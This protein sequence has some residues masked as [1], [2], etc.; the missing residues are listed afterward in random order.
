MPAQIING[1]T[2]SMREQKQDVSMSTGLPYMRTHRGL[3]WE[4]SYIVPL[5][6]A[7]AGSIVSCVRS[8]RCRPIPDRCVSIN[9]WALLRLDIRS[10]P[11]VSRRWCILSARSEAKVLLK[12]WVNG[13]CPVLSQTKC[14]AHAPS[15]GSDCPS[16][17][18]VWP[19]CAEGFAGAYSNGVRSLIHYAHIIHR[20]VEC[21]P[22]VPDRRTWGCQAERA[23]RHPY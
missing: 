11:P 18:H 9:D 20:R 5:P 6:R 22:I 23:S 12:Y 21:V 19:V 2:H 13:P 4:R 3:V 17:A 16:G 1:L 14:P 8:I 15:Q 7:Q 10:L